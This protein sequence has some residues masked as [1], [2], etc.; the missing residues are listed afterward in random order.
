MPKPR[1]RSERKGNLVETG[2]LYRGILKVNPELQRVTKDYYKVV[3]R[4]E[5]EMPWPGELKEVN[6]W[7]DLWKWGDWREW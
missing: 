5:I 2:W 6:S 1:D 4:V 3:W 7:V